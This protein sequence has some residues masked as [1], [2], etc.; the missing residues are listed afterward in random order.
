ME[1]KLGLNMTPRGN[2]SVQMEAVSIQKEIV[3]GDARLLDNCNYT[4]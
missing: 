3:A 2:M 1:I 4:P